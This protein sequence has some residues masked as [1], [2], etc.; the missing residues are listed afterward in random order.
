[1]IGQA[2]YFVEADVISGNTSI[3]ALTALGAKPSFLLNDK[4]YTKVTDP[5]D[6]IWLLRACEAFTKY[7]TQD[8]EKNEALR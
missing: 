5:K 4:V 8:L 6:Q 2:H 1:M 3:Q 7:F